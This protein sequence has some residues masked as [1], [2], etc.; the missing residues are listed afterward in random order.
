MGKQSIFHMWHIGAKKCENT[1][2]WEICEKSEICWNVRNIVKKCE[3]CEKYENIQN[4][5]N[6]SLDFIRVFAFRAFLS[7]FRKSCE[8]WRILRKFRKIIYF[9]W[10]LYFCKNYVKTII[11]RLFMSKTSMSKERHPLTLSGS[12]VIWALI[13]SARSATPSPPYTKSHY[14]MPNYVIASRPNY[15]TLASANINF[16]SQRL[17]LMLTKVNLA[18]TVKNKHGHPPPPVP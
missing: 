6:V 11:S 9:L 1:N 4:F 2:S 5:I 8:S 18:V 14:E 10:K 12:Y 17:M 7:I 15:I 3:K 16:P 13:V